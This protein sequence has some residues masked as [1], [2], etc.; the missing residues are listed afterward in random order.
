MV[1]VWFFYVL[2]S[3][4]VWGFSAILDKIILTKHLSS[5][6]YFVV[7]T[8]PILAAIA[9]ILLFIPVSFDPVP[10]YSAFFAGPLAVLGY[11]F[12][13]FAMKREEASRVATLSSSYPAFVAVLAAILIGEIF[14]LKTYVGMAIMILGA[15]LISYKRGTLKKLIPLAI[16]IMIITANFLYAAEHTISK[17]SMGYYSFWQFFVIYLIGRTFM[18]LPSL[19]IPGFRKT[20][21]GEIKNLKRKIAFLALFSSVIWLLGMITF[22]YA[23][24]LG[25]VTLVSTISIASPLVTLL[26]VVFMS[27]FWPRTLKEEIGRT[28]FSLKLVSILLIIFG[29]YLVTF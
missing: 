18:I 1:E 29:L 6:S 22:F 7:F 9:G 19:A 25:P 5:F 3:V 20:F 23:V 14:S 17:I 4:V 15:T 27:K 2:C 24:S 26:F 28:A 12:Y 10:F 21:V 8:P 16:I 13:A 11:Y